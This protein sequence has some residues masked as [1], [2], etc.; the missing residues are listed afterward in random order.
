M[1]LIIA[2]GVEEAIRDARALYYRLVLVCGAGGT[3]KTAILNEA[4]RRHD[5]KILNLSLELSEQLLDLTRRERALEIPR[6]LSD[7]AREESGDLVMLDN[8]ELLFDPDLQQ[9]PLRLLQG[10]A[11]QRTIVAAWPGVLNDSSLVYAEPGHP[12]HRR[13]SNPEAVLVPMQE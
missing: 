8:I 9:D 12:E 6:I 2:E 13:Y 7:L 11:R 4:A 3:G 1:P 10:L 5:S